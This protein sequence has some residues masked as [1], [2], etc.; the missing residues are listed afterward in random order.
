MPAIV[1]LT[2]VPSLRA[3][4]LLAKSLVTKKIAACVSLRGDFL[5]YYRWSGKLECTR[6]AMLIVKTTLKNFPKVRRLIE[7]SHNYTVPEILALPVK[8]GSAPYLKWIQESVQ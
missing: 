1:V 4:K 5:S 8:R 6:E 2:T 7:T 3:A